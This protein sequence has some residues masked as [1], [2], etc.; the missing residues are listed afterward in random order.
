ML[1]FS[2]A[3]MTNYLRWGDFINIYLFVTIL[4]VGKPKIKM[5]PDLIADE[6]PLPGLQIA[7]SSV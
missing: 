6:S 3:V 4:E 2:Q 5:L 1:W 7:I